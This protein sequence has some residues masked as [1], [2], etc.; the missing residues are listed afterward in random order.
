VLQAQTT[1]QWPPR[2]GFIQFE[3]SNV[4]DTWHLPVSNISRAH[5]STERVVQKKGERPSGLLP[6]VRF[7]HE[8]LRYARLKHPK[9]IWRQ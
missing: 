4:S 7:A 5:V 1:K 2:Y 9:N 8:W 6:S 3:E